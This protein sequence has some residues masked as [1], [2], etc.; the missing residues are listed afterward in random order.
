MEFPVLPEGFWR[1]A[2]SPYAA[3]EFL[4]RVESWRKTMIEALRGPLPDPRLTAPM[5]VLLLTALGGDGP[6][7]RQVRRFPRV[8]TSEESAV[9]DAREVA[10]WR[11]RLVDYLSDVW[12]VIGAPEFDLPECAAAERLLAPPPPTDPGEGPRCPRCLELLR[13]L[14]GSSGFVVHD[15][16]CPAL[17]ALGAPR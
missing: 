12:D 13:R 1:V 15:D 8:G 5:V 3:R 4:V 10:L 14:S 16:T 9:A 11:A 17:R 7:P 2:A 6:L